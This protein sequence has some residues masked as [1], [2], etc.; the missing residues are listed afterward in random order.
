MSHSLPVR[1]TTRH[2]PLL[3]AWTH[4]G[5]ETTALTRWTHHRPSAPTAGQVGRITREIVIER[6]DGSRLNGVINGLQ[7]FL[8]RVIERGGGAYGRT[9]RGRAR[10]T[11]QFTADVEKA[12]VRSPLGRP[13]TRPAAVAADKAFAYSAPGIRAFLRRRRIK[14]V[15]PEKADQAANRKNKGSR[16]GRPASHDAD[17]YEGRNTVERGINEIKDSRGLWHPLRGPRELHRWTPPARLRHPAPQ[18]EPRSM[19]RTYDNP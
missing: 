11:P 3:P 1:S 12:G 13:R 15:V 4:G 10:T 8:P 18:P 6:R 5:T 17:L 9:P 14:A 16:D 7:T 2:G 19:I